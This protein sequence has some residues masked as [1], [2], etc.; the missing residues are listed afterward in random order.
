M[1]ELFEGRRTYIVLLIPLLYGLY[2]CFFT[3]PPLFNSDNSSWFFFPF[4]PNHKMEDVISSIWK[5]CLITLISFLLQYVNYPDI[6]N[7]LFVVVVTCILYVYYFFI[8]SRL[9]SRS[10]GLSPAHISAF[11]Q[12]ITIC[13]VNFV[14]AMVY[15]CMQFL[16]LPDYFVYVGHAT[17]QLGSGNF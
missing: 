12:C 8:L 13:T 14:C 4:T 16:P 3:P 1:K 6:V 15:V 17:W 9:Y 2:I 5:L 11:L 10:A 7:N